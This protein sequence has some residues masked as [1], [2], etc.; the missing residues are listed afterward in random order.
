MDIN[1]ST[2]EVRAAV[3][4][5]RLH[6]GIMSDRVQ[7]TA[8]QMRGLQ[9]AWDSPAGEAIRAKFEI[10]AKRYLENHRRVVESYATFLDNYVATGYEAAEQNLSS[11]ADAFRI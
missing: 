9:A 4:R 3:A 10:A 1:I 7:D 2:E 11:N 5:I 8:N 6:N